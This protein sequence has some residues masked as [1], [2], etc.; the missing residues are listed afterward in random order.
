MTREELLANI[1]ERFTVKTG[2]PGTEY[3]T[4]K[5]GPFESAE[6]CIDHWLDQFNAAIGL[7]AKGTLYWILPTFSLLG[8]DKAFSM[9]PPGWYS[10]GRIRFVP[11]G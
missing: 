7:E 5:G 1:K 2:P 11:A 3:Q 6:Q 9:R 4:I 10:H 8:D